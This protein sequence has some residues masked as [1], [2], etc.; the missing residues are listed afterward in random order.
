MM[1]HSTFMMHVII[2]SITSA[3]GQIFIFHVI[4]TYGP[5]VFTIIM[6]L[7]QIFSII[8]SAVLFGHKFNTAAWGGVFIVGCSLFAKV[9]LK[10]ADR[11]KKKVIGGR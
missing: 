6:T 5:L 7:R 3:T 8:L 1:R 11:K 2:L 9:Y 10:D 4:G